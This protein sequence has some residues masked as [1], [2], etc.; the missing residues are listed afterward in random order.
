M[1]DGGKERTKKGPRK[2]AEPTPKQAADKDAPVR[3]EK[4]RA[5]LLI[6]DI[7]KRLRCSVRRVGA[8]RLV[9]DGLLPVAAIGSIDNRIRGSRDRVVNWVNSEPRGTLGQERPPPNPPDGR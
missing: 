3:H 6:D 4:P 5:V 2:P 1:K 7:A 9:A 8:K